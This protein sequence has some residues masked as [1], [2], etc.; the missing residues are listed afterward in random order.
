MIRFEAQFL[1]RFFLLIIFLFVTSN[2]VIEA[3]F[4]ERLYSIRAVALGGAYAALLNSQSAIFG[5]PSSLAQNNNRRASILYGRSF[6]LKELANSGISIPLYSGR[7]N[8]E[9]GLS[10][11]GFS[12][13]H[14]DIISIGIGK[15][16][17]TNGAVGMALRYLSTEIRG[18]G[19]A[20]TVGLDIGFSLKI[21]SKLNLGV[22][23]KNVN[24]PKLSKSGSSLARSARI[25]ASFTVDDNVLLI[26]E[27]QKEENEVT[28]YRIG[29][30]IEILSDQYLRFGITSNPSNFSMGFGFRLDRI[31]INYSFNTHPYLEASQFF[32]FGYIF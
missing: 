3:A 23:V 30:E 28:V 25:G 7:E 19:S 8:I 2:G 14:E 11:F 22:S 16:I 24:A 4:E 9:I 5:N 32:S 31:D 10:R 20:S 21:N 15:R 27:Y 18:Y 17:S 1:K 13:Y 6:G 29:S 26:A 12:L